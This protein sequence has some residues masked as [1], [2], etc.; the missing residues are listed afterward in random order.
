MMNPLSHQFV[1]L[2][3]LINIFWENIFSEEINIFYNVY[4]LKF[5]FKVEAYNFLCF[6]DQGVWLLYLSILSF[7]NITY[8]YN[9]TYIFAYKKKKKKTLK[10]KMLIIYVLLDIKTSNKDL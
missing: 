8:Y 6:I 2:K 4:Y 1:Y 5:F 7:S 10:H 3:M 9:V